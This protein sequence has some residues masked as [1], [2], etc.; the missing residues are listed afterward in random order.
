MFG[1][2]DG[3]VVTMRIRLDHELLTMKEAQKLLQISRCEVDRLI[4]MGQ[5]K[6][7]HEGSQWKIEG[8]SLKHL[9]SGVSKNKVCDDKRYE[10]NS[11]VKA[12]AYEMAVVSEWT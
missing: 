2:E 5:L 10:K 1:L 11:E 3:E 4:R 7:T 9:L 6:A 12:S 8:R